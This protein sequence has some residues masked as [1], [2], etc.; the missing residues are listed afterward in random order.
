MTMQEWEEYKKKHYKH[1]E[2][3]LDQLL[4]K[5]W[6]QKE[7]RLEEILGD[8]Q[9]GKNIDVGEL[10][11][12][13]P[14]G[15]IIVFPLKRVKALKTGLPSLAEEEIK[16][17]LL[18]HSIYEYKK[19]IP[20][21]FIEKLFYELKSSLIEDGYH[22]GDFKCPPIACILLK[23]KHYKEW[24][25]KTY[26]FHK[27]EEEYGTSIPRKRVAD[28]SLANISMGYYS[29]LIIVKKL[30]K[31]KYYTNTVKHELLHI[32][33]AYLKLPPGTL[34]RRYGL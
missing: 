29:F 24:T 23:D 30:K 27:T 31:V 17:R 25:R 6:E 5:T 19:F 14:I 32:F 33:E 13:L 34:T 12:C 7:T 21:Q 11:A 3:R 28:L 22:L 9:E 16:A 15:N 1:Y 20:Y 10:V 2:S 8:I 18:Q 26:G 4:Q